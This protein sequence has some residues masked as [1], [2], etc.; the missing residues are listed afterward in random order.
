MSRRHQPI[1]PPLT[2]PPKDGWPQRIQFLKQ[3]PLFADIA[4]AP[5]QTIAQK[6]VPRYFQQGDIIFHEG[7]PG[8]FLYLVQSGQVRIFVNGQDGSETS[9][10]LFGKPGDIFGELA[11]IDGLTRSASAVALGA[12]VLYT[13]SREDFREQM[14]RYPQLALNFMKVLSLRMRYNTRQ[15]EG[16]VTL[17]VPKRLAHKLME[18]ASKLRPCPGQRRPHRH[19]SDANQPG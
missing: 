8:L 18:L 7:D 13:M 19:G 16:L 17:D 9:V 3:T 5:L 15:M 4:A 12:T 10:I 11:V 2:V 1:F 14:R 6:I